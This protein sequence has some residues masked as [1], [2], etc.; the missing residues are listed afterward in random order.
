[1]GIVTINNS[2]VEL[3]FYGY[4]EGCKLTTEFATS[5]G[6]VDCIIRRKLYGRVIVIEADLWRS[7]RERALAITLFSTRVLM[8]WDGRRYVISEK[9]NQTTTC[10]L[11]ELENLISNEII[12]NE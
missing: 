2:T 11:R 6:I 4:V 5:L 9:G 3:D 1:M 7:D 12:A 10:Y 8:A